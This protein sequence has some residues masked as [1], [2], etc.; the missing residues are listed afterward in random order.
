[1]A[2]REMGDIIPRMGCVLEGHALSQT[3]GAEPDT[4]ELFREVSFRWEAP[5]VHVV[6]GYSGEG[7]SG[8]LKSIGGVWKPAKGRL[9][10]N[11]RPLWGKHSFAQDQ[12]TLRQLGFAFQN[13][14]LFN[15][16][17]VLENLCFPHRQRFPQVPETER[18]ALAQE[19]LRKVGLEHAAA[20]F[21]H[22][23]S[24]GMQKRLSIARA[25]ILEPEFI[26]LD[27]PTAGL[28]PITSKNMADLIRDLLKGREALV[29][30]VTNDPDRARDWGENIHFLVDAHLHSPGS[31]G[32][33]AL[34]EK[35]L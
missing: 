2:S 8:L 21:P 7:K 18:R 14:A 24:G 29:V 25:L 32:Y 11:G 35:F 17:R 34:R 33:E 30:I 15:S 4:P 19:W 16:L 28:D 27:D 5:S 9:L 20:Q 31:P 6:M 13:N 23:L 3:L 22:E 10:A 1:M 12:E 26:F